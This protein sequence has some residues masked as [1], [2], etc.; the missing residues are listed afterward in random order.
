LLDD[1]EGD[2]N[3][4]IALKAQL[5]GTAQTPGSGGASANAVGAEQHMPDAH[6]AALLHVGIVALLNP[7]PRGGGNRPPA[8]AAA[9]APRSAAPSS[10]GQPSAAEGA[11]AATAP[12][13]SS[14]GNFISPR[15]AFA[16][17]QADA[18]KRAFLLELG[19][20]QL[21]LP[22]PRDHVDDIAALRLE[23]GEKHLGDASP[24]PN[25]FLSHRDQPLETRVL[26]RGELEQP[27]DPV[28]PGL[29]E[30]LLAGFD[31]PSDLPPNQR[32][33][34]LARWIASDR[35]LLTARVVANRVWQWHFG[36]G[37]VRTPNDFG[38]RGERPS[39]PEL[40][41]WLASEL[42]AHGWSL[43]HLHRVIMN[44]SAYRM[45]AIAG[46]ATL[47]RDPDNV[48][49]SRFQPHRLQA[50][51]IW[52]KI[53]AAAGTLDLT[54]HGLPIAPPLDEQE[55]L[56]NYR[57]WPASTPE[58]SNRRAI[59]LLVKRSFRF[60]MLSAFDLPDNISS[61]GRRDITTVPN[62]ALTLL[63]NR[64]MQQQAAAF[65]ARLRA[66]T[67]GQLDAVPARA[68]LHAYGRRVSADE[69]T[70]AL[71]FLQQ[72]GGS[73]SAVAELCLA[74]FNTNEFIYQQ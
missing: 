54:L 13:S 60:P 23:I 30:A 57:K 68:W 73:W 63:N 4:T 22:K 27:G 39:H 28:S 35:N 71:G 17:L 33:A 44:S 3:T 49:L 40:L 59:Y 21:D 74:L 12:S 10:S 6:E 70:Q 36:E 8:A 43:K 66:E 31:F 46:A 64:T 45:A 7:A 61:C 15:R 41:D 11:A 26:K 62:Q 67:N 19:R 38:V 72:R 51:I 65:A 20:Q 34:A 53:R 32:R 55:Q 1:E 69:R 42:V 48:L 52:D 14:R 56:G 9:A 58:E 47:E 25:R 24:I 5:R 50:E 18:E 37:L 16:A 29:P 2:D